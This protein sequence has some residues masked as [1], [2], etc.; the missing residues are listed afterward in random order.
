MYKAF[1]K[2]LTLGGKSCLGEKIPPPSRLNPVQCQFLSLA[3][4]VG[5]SVSHTIR[6]HMFLTSNLNRLHPHCHLIL[7]CRKRY[8]TGNRNHNAMFTVQQLTQAIFHSIATQLMSQFFLFCRVTVYKYADAQVST[9]LKSKVCH[10]LHA[11]V[12]STM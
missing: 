6:I 2:M 4:S 1:N 10:M 3:D 9:I 8:F 7:G 11:H 12:G 5:V